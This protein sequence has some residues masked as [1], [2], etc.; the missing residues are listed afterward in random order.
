[1][2]LTIEAPG[3]AIDSGGAGASL[4]A[5]GATTGPA[6]TTAIAQISAALQVA[7]QSYLIDVYLYIDG[8]AAAATDDDNMRLFFNGSGQVTIPVNGTAGGIL[9]PYKFS[10]TSPPSTAAQPIQI[11]SIVAGTSTATYHVTIV[12]TPVGP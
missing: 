8:T 6:A 4:S 3:P 12:A 11:Q 10:W 1:M 2:G 5:H 7:G 9:A